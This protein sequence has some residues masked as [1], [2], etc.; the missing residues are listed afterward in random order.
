MSVGPRYHLGHVSSGSF[1]C[2]YIGEFL[3]E[4]EDEEIP[5]RYP[6]HNNN[7]KVEFDSLRRKD[8]DGFTIYVVRYGNVGR[9]INCSC[10]SNLY[11]TYHYNYHIDHVCDKNSNMN[12][13]NCRC[14]SRKYF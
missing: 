14:G 4:K 12:R 13:K 11:F 10:S 1:I 3:D 5:K 2:E 9:F 6:T 8:E 7:L